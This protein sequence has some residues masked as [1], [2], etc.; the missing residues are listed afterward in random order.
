MPPFPDRSISSL[1]AP[2]IKRYDWWYSLGTMIGIIVGKGV[3]QNSAKPPNIVYLQDDRV[4]LTL[5]ID[6]AP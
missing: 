2:E 4:L 3:K 5:K 6:N 1:H